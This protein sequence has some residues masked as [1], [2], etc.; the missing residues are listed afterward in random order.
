MCIRDRWYQRRVR[1]TPATSNMS[2]AGI[3]ELNP[4]LMNL[5]KQDGT[6]HDG[7]EYCPYTRTSKSYDTRR[8]N[9]GADIV[10]GNAL[11]SGTPL[12][13][14]RLLDV[15]CGT[16]SWLEQMRPHFAEVCGL[17]YNDGMLAQ[18]VARFGT[19][20]S[21]AHGSAQ[22]IPHPDS[23]VDVVTINQVIHHFDSKDNFADLATA[24]QV[25]S[26]C[27]RCRLGAQ[28]TRCDLCNRSAIEYSSP[29]AD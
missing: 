21:L 18:A 26:T 14:Q 17:E 28:A 1:G 29:E 2:T 22:N 11:T 20:V 24:L 5:K 9:P 6:T 7:V 19:E 12:G 15:G 27:K 13:T 8:V 23:S 10:L 16:G 3:I 4:D 25:R